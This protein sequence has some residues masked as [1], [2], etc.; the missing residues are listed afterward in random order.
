MESLVQ[1]NVMYLLAVI[2]SKNVKRGLSQMGPEG[3]SSESLKWLL[4]NI[5]GTGCLQHAGKRYHQR[6]NA[7]TL[8]AKGPQNNATL[9]AW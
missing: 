3:F 9:S 5:A 1:G 2:E 7:T 6:N 4:M 8:S